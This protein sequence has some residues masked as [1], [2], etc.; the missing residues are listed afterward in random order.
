MSDLEVLT[1]RSLGGLKV[2]SVTD[3]TP[4]LNALIYGESGAGKTLLS[5][6][7]SLVEAMSPVVFIDIEGGTFTIRNFGDVDVVRAKS[8]QDVQKVYDDLYDHPSK[9]KTVVIDSLTEMQKFN[10]MGIMERLVKK[11]PDRDPDI[12]SVREWGQSIEQIRKMTRAFRDLPINAIFTALLVQERDTRT[13]LTHN[14]PSLPGKLSGEISGFMDEVFYLYIVRKTQGDEVT[15]KRMVLTDK[16][17]T[18]VAK[19][20]SGKLPLLVEEP[21]MNVLYSH[22]FGEAA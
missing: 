13:G 21:T 4:F 20:R 11:E 1:E 8:F 2:Q 19:D 10:M 18:T 14:K 16:T 17:D 12:P 6:T 7:A 5:G 3:Q 9:Y 22:M 15:T